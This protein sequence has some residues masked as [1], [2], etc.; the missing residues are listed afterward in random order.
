M[1]ACS[2]VEKNSNTPEGAFAVAEEF[3]KGERYEEAV[4]HYTEVKNKFP[5]SNY[6]TRAELAIADVHFKQESYAEAQVSYQ[7]FKDMHPTHPRIDYVQYRLGMSYFN[8]LPTSID[9]DLSLANDTILAFSDLIRKYP[10]SEYVKEATEKRTA[11]IHMLAE[12]EEY[13]ADFY[14]KREIWLSALNRYENLY[15]TYG[16]LGFDKKALTR[17]VVC[18]EKL[19]EKSKAQK[20]ADILEEKYPGSAEARKAEKEVQ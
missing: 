9:R 20:Y 11:T 15:K 19:N 6:A 18:A 8:Q 1:S 4:R 3:D 12:K 2:T 7:M 17:A 5:Y 16:D 10:N 13:I 14:Y